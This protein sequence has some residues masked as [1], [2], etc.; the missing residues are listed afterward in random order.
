MKVSIRKSEPT[1]STPWQGRYSNSLA[2]DRRGDFVTHCPH[3]CRR[4]PCKRTKTLS[5]TQLYESFRK[6]LLFTAK[7][8]LVLHDSATSPTR[9]FE[10]TVI[11]LD[12]HGWSLIQSKDRTLAY[13]PDQTSLQ[14]A[15]FSRFA[16]TEIT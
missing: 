16:I 10:S 5:R 6:C 11:P 3:R 15:Y 7:T 4:R 1:T 8:K 13:Y 9:S 12:I 14:R 2:N